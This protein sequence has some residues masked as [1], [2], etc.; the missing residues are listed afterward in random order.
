MLTETP[1]PMILSRSS[2]IGCNSQQPF[3]HCQLVVPTA[4]AIYTENNK[5]SHSG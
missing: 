4:I 1:D 3:N 2:V 5:N